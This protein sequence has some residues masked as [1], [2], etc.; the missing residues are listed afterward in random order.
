VNGAHFNAVEINA[1][2]YRIPSKVFDD[3]VPISERL[4]WIARVDEQQ[5]GFAAG[6][7]IDSVGPNASYPLRE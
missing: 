4:D 7:N 5:V 6:A 3:A 1:D 2:E